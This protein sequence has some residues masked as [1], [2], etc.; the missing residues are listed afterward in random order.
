[1]NVEENDIDVHGRGT[2][3][4]VT[5]FFHPFGNEETPFG[6]V[7]P[8]LRNLISLPNRHPK[9]SSPSSNSNNNNTPATV[10]EQERDLRHSTR[11]NHEFLRIP[12]IIVVP[13]ILPTLIETYNNINDK[14]KP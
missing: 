9:T 10:S 3:V 1:V 8:F 6:V 12:E 14:D 7:D 11:K 2:H 13:L 4:P 5:V